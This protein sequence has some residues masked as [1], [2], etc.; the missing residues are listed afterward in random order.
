MAKL[1]PGDCIAYAAKFLKNTGDFSHASA[2]RRGVLLSLDPGLKNYG[3]VKWDDFESRAAHY[4]EQYGEDYVAEARAN[5]QLVC[6]SN[7][8]KVGS[9]R[10]ALNDL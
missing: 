5:G 8:A 3:R 9:P 4:A 2:S 6:L 7:V 10:F 1:Q